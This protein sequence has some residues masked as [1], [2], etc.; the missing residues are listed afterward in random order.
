[1]KILFTERN[2]HIDIIELLIQD[3]DLYMQRDYG[4]ATNARARTRMTK[5]EH[6]FLCS[7]WRRG[8]IGEGDE[9]GMDEIRLQPCLRCA[10]QPVVLILP[11]WP[12]ARIRVECCA[13]GQRG[14]TVYF[15]AGGAIYQGTEQL[16]PG[17]AKARREAAML[18]NNGTC[19]SGGGASG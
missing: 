12:Y 6:M 16:L 10:G 1:M 7:V 17:L 19:G 15:D 4:A 9:R 5:C 3:S 13:C 8:I 14:P 18:W 11:G 2:F